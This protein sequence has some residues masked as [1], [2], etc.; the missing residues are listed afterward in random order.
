MGGLNHLPG[1]L[2]A[3]FNYYQWIALG[4]LGVGLAGFALTRQ[5]VQRDWEFAKP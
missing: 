3:P 5:P 4:M 2:L 1:P